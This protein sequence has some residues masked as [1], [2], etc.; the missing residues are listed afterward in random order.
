MQGKSDE[1]QIEKN[2]NTTNLERDSINDNG[3]KDENDSN[4]KSRLA[5]WEALVNA[6]QKVSHDYDK[7]LLTISSGAIGLSFIAIKDFTTIPV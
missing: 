1:R 7:Y 4:D 3:S 2:I 5:Y 6:E